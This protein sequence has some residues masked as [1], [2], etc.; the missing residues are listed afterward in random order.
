MKNRTCNKCRYFNSTGDMD[1]FED[2][3]IEPCETA[4]EGWCMAPTPAY[5]DCDRNDILI[6]EKLAKSCLM[7]KRRK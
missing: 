2:D 6:S 4:K 5:V 3:E 1:V 7:F